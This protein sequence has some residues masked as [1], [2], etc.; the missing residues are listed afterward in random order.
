[1]TDFSLLM[2]GHE[3]VIECAREVFAARKTDEDGGPSIDLA[4]SIVCLGEA[5]RLLDAG[6]HG[7]AREILEGKSGGEAA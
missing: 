2:P 6:N 4:V 7:R 5:L 3:L 1:M